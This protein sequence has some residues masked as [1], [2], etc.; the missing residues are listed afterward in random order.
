MMEPYNDAR[1][2]RRI[3]IAFGVIMVAAG[4]GA[5]VF[6]VSILAQRGIVD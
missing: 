5:L 1:A 4:L 6:W 2:T 3:E